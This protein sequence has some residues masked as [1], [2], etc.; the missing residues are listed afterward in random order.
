MHVIEAICKTS[1]RTQSS[2]ILRLLH[3]PVYRRYVVC[4]EARTYISPIDVTTV[5]LPQ[6]SL[7]RFV[8]HHRDG[9]RR[10]PTNRC[11]ERQAPVVLVTCTPLLGD[12]ALG[13][14]GLWGLV[15]WNCSVCYGSAAAVLRYTKAEE[16]FRRGATEMGPQTC[17]G[18]L[19]AACDTSDARAAPACASSAAADQSRIR[20]RSGP[21][22]LGDRLINNPH[23]SQQGLSK[24][25]QQAPCPYPKYYPTAAA[26]GSPREH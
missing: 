19:R 4:W 15:R 24:K 14:R 12:S 5:Q 6:Q 23:Y 21:G 3:H 26:C 11:M 9:R 25:Q 1:Q 22:T 16:R 18:I 7:P 17:C 8:D 2:L 13:A 10:I 20:P